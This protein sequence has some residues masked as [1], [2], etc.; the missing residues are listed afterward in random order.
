M[1][2][3][4]M[5][6]LA[7]VALCLTAC[8]GRQTIQKREIGIPAP[9]STPAPT[10][11]PVQE[12]LSRE[13]LLYGSVGLLSEPTVLVSVYLNNGTERWTEEEIEQ[14]RKNLSLAME[15]ISDQ[16]REYGC[17]V[18]LYYDDGK[19]TD[20]HRSQSWARPFAA[21]RD[22][23]EEEA[24][25]FAADA[26]CEQLDTEALRAA[27]GTDRIGFLYFVP[28]AGGDHTM[29]HYAQD[30]EWYYYE[31][32]VLYRQDAYEPGE[33]FDSPTAY[34]H[35]ILHLFG[36][37]DLYEDSPD[38]CVTEE[39]SEYMWESWPED[40]MLS[41]YDGDAPI[42]YTA[43]HKIL[44]PVTAYRVGLTDSFADQDLFPAMRDSI[45][46]VYDSGEPLPEWL[47]LPGQESEFPAWVQGPPVAA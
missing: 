11:A 9:Q 25:Y 44:S 32:C 36:A 10:E 43:I 42:D 22:Y 1:R 28:A 14:S 26:W 29:I 15:W 13:E 30:L 16:A 24:F 47:M 2:R 23:D 12:A 21:G 3:C 33:P 18:Q 39:M 8:S 46:G 31:Y 19:H 41:T 17:E 4:L 34:A 5:A 6:V 45:P 20:L 7:A 38:L 27:Y 37:A 35:E 40:I